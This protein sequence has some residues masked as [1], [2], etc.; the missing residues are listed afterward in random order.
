MALAL[1]QPTDGKITPIVLGYL[2]ANGHLQQMS[3]GGGALT[4]T[5]APITGNFRE[6]Q[7]STKATVSASAAGLRSYNLV[8]PNT[9]P[10]Y[11]KLYDALEANVT[12][13]TTAP[14]KTIAIP[15]GGVWTQEDNGV[16]QRAFATG[17]VLAVTK[18]LDDSDATALDSSILA[19]IAFQ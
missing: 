11:A 14:V 17:I 4:V 18:N 1:L 9:Y 6:F 15:S 5:A 7:N 10:V 19:E 3:G 8:N 12:V 2:D 13:G 16:I